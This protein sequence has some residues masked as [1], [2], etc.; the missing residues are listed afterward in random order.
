[1]SGTR[2]PLE[3]LH[4]GAIAHLASSSPEEAAEWLDRHGLLAIG[5]GSDGESAPGLAAELP[6]A[7]RELLQR[8]RQR[9]LAANLHRIARFQ[10][11]VDALAEEGI[12]ACPL[13]GI[14]L[15]GTVYARDPEHR[16]MAD[17]DL[18]VPAEA[19]EAAVRRLSSALG[20]RETALSRRHAPRSHER[21]LTGPA[22]VVEVH[23]RLGLR[24]GRA[25]AWGDLDPEPARLH[26][27]DVFVLDPETTLAYLLAHFV[28]HVPWSRLVWVEDLLRWSGRGFDP[29]R[30]VE[31]AR[32]LGIR[33]CLVAAVRTLRRELG[34]ELGDAELGDAELGEAELGGGVLTGLPDRDRGPGSPLLWLYEAVAERRP[35][36]RAARRAAV[37]GRRGSRF[38]RHLGTLLLADRPTDLVPFLLTRGPQAFRSSQSKAGSR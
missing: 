36:A 25:G 22:L 34:A 29:E 24:T 5:E 17:V 4:R 26:E 20:L 19:I 30:T 12:P 27:R 6:A 28:Q 13:K 35:S 9:T 37:T 31:R 16:P 7:V 15:L 18:L 32:Q 14:H 3:V 38:L 33:R 23:T 21:V 1:M 10:E 2:D 11:M 8:Q